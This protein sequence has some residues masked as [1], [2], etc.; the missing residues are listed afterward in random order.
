M[1]NLDVIV[2]YFD[3]KCVKLTEVVGK[4]PAKAEYGG[5]EKMKHQSGFVA[6][7][8]ALLL[9]AIASNANTVVVNKNNNAGWVTAITSESKASPNAVAEYVDGGV[10]L[11]SGGVGER[12]FLKTSDF[13][14]YKIGDIT[15]FTYG[16]WTNSAV[17][18]PAAASPYLNL[19]VYDT[20]KNFKNWYLTLVFDSSLSNGTIVNA[21]EQD[22]NG[23]WHQRNILKQNGADM[24]SLSY[25]KD[26]T[27]YSNLITGDLG[28]SFNVGDS[29]SAAWADKAAYIDYL[30]IGFDGNE[31]TTYDFGGLHRASTPAA[32]PEPATM[33][34]Y[35]LGMGA[36]AFI[37][38]AVRK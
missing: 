26:Y 27:I 4:Q 16:Y 38:R 11:E 1:I 22:D 7:L 12:S 15:T 5:I 34:L 29:S 28:F 18:S 32:V 31:A 19:F 2:F 17:S 33:L 14:G 9:P 20:K 21:L 30:T 3:H 23:T 24:Q 10:L 35:S 25:W 13:D 6:L 37:K 8:A 36:A